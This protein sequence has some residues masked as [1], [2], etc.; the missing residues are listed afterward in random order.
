MSGVASN[1]QQAAAIAARGQV[2]VSAGAGTGKTTVLVERFVEAVCERGIDVQSMLVITY[3]E[4][5]AGELKG[6]IRARLHEL[7]RH[8]LARSLDG[9]WISTIHGFCLRLL[10]SHPFAAGLDPRF[11]I[12]DES[13]GRVIRGESF[14]AALNQ[15]CAGEDSERLKLLATYGASGLRRMLTT[16]Y[17]TLRSAGRELEL[18]LGERAEVGVRLDELASA[19]RALAADPEATDAA[20]TAA[21]QAMALAEGTRTPERLLDLGGLRARGER[22]VTYE[23]AR[24]AVEQAALDELALQDRELLQEL[25][26]GFAAQYA[27][28]KERESALDFEDLQLCARDLLRDDA[29]LRDREQLRFRSIMVDEFQDTNRLQCEL[30]DL[31]T[32]PD[33]ER[34]FVGDEFQSIYGFRH[35]D[36]Q[37]FRERRE[38]AA[39]LLPLTRNY[40]SRPEVLAVVNHLFGA[41]FGEEFQPLAASGEFPDPV[42]GTPVE[43]L[44]TDKAAYAG[45]GMHWRRAEA[46]NAAQRVKELVDSGAATAGEIVLLFAAGTDAEWYEEELREAGLATYR[47][48]G[49]GYFGQ[50]QVVDLLSYLRLLQNRYDDEALVSVLASPF[51]GVSNDA[52]LL[53]RRA[54]RGPI[55]TGI[56]RSL[57]ADLDEA[58]IRLLRAF[59]Q[60]YD[61][62]TEAAPR[63]SLERL[64]DRIVADHDYDLAVLAQW[65]GRRRYA[66]LRKLARLARS[67]EEL[68]GPDVEGFVRFVEEQEA[69]GA[70]ERDAVAEEEG[71]DAVR[72]L[73]I[74]AA[75]GLEFK[76]VVV[77]DAG[78]DRNAP[79]ADEILC[80]ADGRFG[81][82]VADPITGR[83]HGVLDY[84]RVKEARAAE[85]EAE[86]LRLY[87][88][89]MTRAID[90]LV[91]SGSINTASIDSERKALERTPIGWVLGRLECAAEVA[92][93]GEQPLELER[94]GA[95]VLV[96]V[97][98]GPAPAEQPV[99]ELVPAVIDG[100]TGQLALFAAGAEPK[101]PPLAPALA[102]IQALPEPPLHDV[103][104]LSYSALALFE[105]CS[106]RYYAERVAGMRPA[107]AHGTVAGQTGLVA[108]EIGDAVHRLL[109]LVDLA[110]PVMPDLE[111]VRAWYPAVTDEELRRIAGFVDS[112]CGSELASRIA[113]LRGARPERPFAFEHDGVLLHGRLDVLHVEGANVL[114]LDYKTNSLAEGR[115]EEIVEADYRLQ[116]L[117]YALAC[118]RAGAEE[119]EVVYHFLERGD[120]VVSTTFARADA[121]ELEA[122]LSEAIGRIRA[123]EF[124]PTPSE[125]TCAGCPAL[126]VVCAG[127]RLRGGPSRPPALAAAG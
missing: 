89:A 52:L 29:A 113:G 62:L 91:V 81:F 96:R 22:A 51:V 98:R 5:A 6:R 53:I 17:E 76:V 65:D 25:L 28:A 45:T 19:A 26:H 9:A 41:E 94:E 34:F 32:G 11:R 112:Y 92:A 12:L 104:R 42:F 59:R 69:V 127:P 50:Q 68:R 77:A 36:V 15:F 18:E 109:E 20:R 10:K 122:E 106:Y 58:D 90:R 115:P 123:G 71:A 121:A 60:R 3:T 7:G 74:H 73:T 37:V 13:Q 103:R 27:A 93:A 107:R 23:D 101:L 79:S 48:T 30:V 95:R 72:L 14:E 83:R 63:L 31:L 38:G 75:K 80:L 100:A 88:V 97:D 24:R 64:C 16:V 2:F 102:P 111:H 85:D 116:R 55:F 44:V 4:R 82:R 43:L 35:A 99:S 120:A 1:E 78:R 56:E 47:A 118:F 54:A 87:Y 49:R 21:A 110:A 39:T 84:D 108:T 119:V 61:R 70:A 124:R 33:A 66:N 8:D 67:Y 117:V 125:F 57:P 86:R 105:R 126:D 46:K 40:R 114:V